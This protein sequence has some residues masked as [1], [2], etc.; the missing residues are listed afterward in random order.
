MDTND[1]GSLVAIGCP[2]DSLGERDQT[3]TWFRYDQGQTQDWQWQNYT[4]AGAVR[5]LESR[6]YYPHRDKAVEFYKY[7]NL[8]L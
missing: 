2:T 1:D 4:N 7:G 6:D 8:H 3:I 5:L